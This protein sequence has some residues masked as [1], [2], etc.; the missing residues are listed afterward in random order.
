MTDILWYSDE[1]DETWG[2]WREVK[3]LPLTARLMRWW[4]K[5]QGH[6]YVVGYSWPA[7]AESATPEPILQACFGEVAPSQSYVLAMLT[8]AGGQGRATV[9][10][11]GRY[12]VLQAATRDKAELCRPAYEIST[13]RP[14]AEL[15]FKAI[16]TPVYE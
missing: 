9:G 15:G 10:V 8:I 4:R 5:K 3:A 6:R 12:D 16:Y 1:V 14:D 2:E 13:A 11:G 7:K